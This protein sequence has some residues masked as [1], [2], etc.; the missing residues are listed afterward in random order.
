MCFV[1]VA[2]HVLFPIHTHAQERNYTCVSRCRLSA[3]D[4]HHTT[5]IKCIISRYTQK[6]V[7]VCFLPAHGDLMLMPSHR[8]GSYLWLDAVYITWPG[9]MYRVQPKQT[10][11][12][13]VPASASAKTDRTVCVGSKQNTNIHMRT[14]WN[15]NI[16]TPMT[17]N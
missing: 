12:V 17:S 8:N 14:L 15:F 10:A 1:K 2:V 11:A 13:V 7:C 4:S 9:A 5:Y 16:W 3:L 6:E